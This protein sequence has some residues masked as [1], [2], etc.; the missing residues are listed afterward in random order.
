MNRQAVVIVLILFTFVLSLKA[1]DKPL[2]PEVI[3]VSVDPF[4]DKVE[5]KWKPS[6]S[7]PS[8]IH[9]YYINQ[10]VSDALGNK[11]WKH[12]DSVGVGVTEWKSKAIVLNKQLWFSVGTKYNFNNE[13]NSTGGFT[14]VS[15][16]E[17][18]EC[19]DRAKIMWN[20]YR[21]WAEGVAK[22]NVYVSETGFKGE[23]NLL[24]T[25]TD[26]LFYHSG[27][28]PK[29]KRYY[30]IIAQRNGDA[31][32]TATTIL[33]NVVAN[34]PTLPSEVMISKM[35]NKDNAEI[36]FTLKVSSDAEYNKFRL[37]RSVDGNAFD[38][39]YKYT[40]VGVK[41][42]SDIGAPTD[43][44]YYA[45]LSI[46]RCRAVNV[47]SDTVRVISATA[48]QAD[49]NVNIK[50]N[51][52]SNKTVSYTVKST[53]TGVERDLVT[54]DNFSSYNDDYSY[55]S[56]GMDN[57][58]CYIV[59]ATFAGKFGDVEVVSNEPCI[60]LKPRIWLPT[61]INPSSVHTAN[62]RFKPELSFNSPYSIAI[63]NRWKDL[64]YFGK[65][66]PWKGV[67]KSGK[68][69]VQGTYIYI[70]KIDY[71]NGKTVEKRGTVTVI[72]D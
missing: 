44:A 59:E 33:T 68:Q 16:T 20:K 34:E 15:Q 56:E 58:I 30:Y 60:G 37:M 3:S 69:V 55:I 13:L 26:T 17:Y 70:V 6:T 32:V 28:K 42:Y 21:G 31:S 39:I 25:T 14:M 47:A 51:K 57:K 35:E 8:L 18:D 27:F 53:N 52:P 65:N 46:D 40:D 41:S 22:Y 7:D 45:L 67:D 48:V 72:Y 61:A 1:E 49:D 38:T 43:E 50:W 64:I 12:I 11:H 10:W 9:G 4:Y 62:R 24:G 71:D 66:E 36:K 2:P 5:I 19:T 23:F 54:K 63:Y 29:D